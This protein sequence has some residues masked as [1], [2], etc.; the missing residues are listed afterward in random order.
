MKR[1][2]RLIGLA[3]VLCAA[4]IAACAPP[5][6][7]LGV[8]VAAA[9][10]DPKL[11]EF[12][13][14][15]PIHVREGGKPSGGG[16][17]G[18]VTNPTPRGLTPAQIRSAYGLPTTGGYGTIAIIDAYDDPKAEA[19]L[20]TFSAQYGL[21]SCTASNGCFQKHMMGAKVRGNQGWGLEIALDVEWAH[22]TAPDAK[23]LLVEAKSSSGTDLLAA[24]D[25]ARARADVVAVSMS[26]GGGE[27]SSEASYDGSFTS[28]YGATFF[29]ASGDSGTGAS[30]PASSPNV[31]SVGGTTLAFNPDGSLASETAWS[32]S[33]GGIS[34]Y[35]PLPSYQAA[36][37]L[38]YGGRAIPDVSANADPASGY[39]VYDSYGYNGQTGWFQVG[40]TSGSTPFM[41]GI[42]S[43]EL[44]ADNAKFYQD[45]AADYGAYFR[46]VTSGANG[47]CGALC[48]ASA[49]YDAVTGL[50]VPATTTF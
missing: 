25:Y 11:D 2:T 50:G 45:A 4:V 34:A 28:A 40:G 44:S 31:T 42:K 37:G 49:G 38:S 16:G 19:D 21:P 43:L 5:E 14:H 39:S 12:Q 46:D 41:A 29:A 47:S 20:N 24:V 35:Q 3:A 26:W 27:F 23:I 48:T 13:A 17:G 8:A 18:G 15:P 6:E 1:K 30:W 10:G 9:K 22:A 36:Y 7:H 32:G 33:G